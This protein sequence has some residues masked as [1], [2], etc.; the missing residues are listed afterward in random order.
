M[1]PKQRPRSRRVKKT[2]ISNL[3]AATFEPTSKFP[4][5]F[6]IIVF[7]GADKAAM[8]NDSVRVVN[9]GGSAAPVISAVISA[10]F[11]F[12]PLALSTQLR[13]RFQE[14]LGGGVA[15]F[16][17]TLL[18]T[19]ISVLLIE[20]T[21]GPNQRL[22]L[23]N[24]LRLFL[25]AIV[26]AALVGTYN[27]RVASDLII[28]LGLVQKLEQ[29]QAYLI[30]ADE[31]ARREIANLLHDSVQSKLVISA[32]KLNAI[33]SKAPDNIAFELQQILHDLE[34]LRRLDVRNASRALSP[35]I[36]VLGLQS[37]LSDLA[38]MYSE[39]M[40]VSLD[41]EDL[42]RWVEVDYGL[43][44][45][46]VCEQVLLNALANGGAGKCIVTVRLNKE[47]LLLNIDNNGKRLDKAFQP[48]K[49]SALIDAWVSRFNGSWSLN[50]TDEHWV[51]MEAQLRL[52]AP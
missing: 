5:V 10:T 43:A 38:S 28:S 32:T 7:L 51:R 26:V 3:L 16:S 6:A 2:L 37:C 19:S 4:A 42:P 45:Y 41:V 20:L 33:A 30:E 15:F 9:F 13:L 44:V 48:A 52:V 24:E 23:N 50:N 35:D 47:A 25:A 22:W 31:K 8:V 11:V 1:N 36:E 40:N 34:N 29:Q 27:R 14:R 49:G 18:S 46:R 21:L 39:S 12:F 17:S